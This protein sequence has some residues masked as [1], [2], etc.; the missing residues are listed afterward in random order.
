MSRRLPSLNALKV[1]EAAARHAS[2]TKAAEELH[3]SQ[4]AV[5]H[6]IKA[7]EEELGVQLFQRLNRA[8]KLTDAAR[9]YLPVLSQ[10]FDEIDRATERLRPGKGEKGWL[11]VSVSPTF[12][13]RWL[14]PRL[15]RW[16]ERHPG[17]ELR[18]SSSARLVDFTREDVDVGVR[19]GRGEWPGLKADRLIAARIVPACSPKLLK[20]LPLKVPADL[21]R[22][23]LLHSQVEPDAWR[24]WLAAAGVDS[25]VDSTRGPQ[26]DT[27]TEAIQAAIEG[28][29][30]AIVRRAL[31]ER[32][33]KAG[34]LTVPF[35]VPLP[36][37]YAFYVVCPEADAEK[38][39][40]KA[41][42]EW[43]IFEARR[44]ESEERPETQ[45]AA[46][47]RAIGRGQAR[48]AKKGRSRRG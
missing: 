40:V 24:M 17:I 13:S 31:V 38:P 2:F 43:A 7:L 16:Q 44:D 41:F 33:I 29:G 45:A 11:N 1:F 37:E 6:Q 27:G 14:I 32:D 22:H 21:V 35:E 9:S 4:A 15:V 36:V 19:H 8:L 12:L 25:L 48:P 39:K 23:T 47:P 30:V 3:V 34:N 26:F 28:M 5:S 42:R 46:K 10:A 20:S 18:V